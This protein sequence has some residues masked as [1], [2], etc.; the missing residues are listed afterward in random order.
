[1]RV[2]LEKTDSQCTYNITL[3]HVH[4]TIVAVEKQ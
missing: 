1:M 3:K 2:R 4:E